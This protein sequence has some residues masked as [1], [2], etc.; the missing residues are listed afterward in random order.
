MPEDEESCPLITDYTE[1]LGFPNKA[2]ELLYRV[3]E[4]DPDEGP[5]PITFPPTIRTITKMGKELRIRN[6][7]T[8]SIAHMIKMHRYIDGHAVG[9]GKS[10]M[11]IT[12]SAYLINKKPGTKVIVLGTKSTTYQWKSEYENFSTLRA[13]VLQDKYEGAKGSEAR[14]KQIE[15]FLTSDNQDV[16]IAKY[17]SLVG[18]RRTLEGE[19]DQDGNP[20]TEG[21]KEEISPEIAALVGIVKKHGSKIVLVLDECQKFKSTTSQIRKMILKIQPYIAVIWAMT[22]TI[23]QNSL[24]EF[25]S[26]SVAIGLR[27]FGPM[28]AFRE[29]FCIYKMVHVGRG[30]H[31]P[32][33]I[34]YKNVKE[35][36]IGMRP[37]YYGRSQAQVKEPLPKLSTTYHPIELDKH[38]AKL[39]DDIRSKKFVLPPS[40]KK[41]TNGEI[42]E[43]ERDPD[44]MMTMLAVT[45][46][47]AN[48]PNLMTPE[49]EKAFYTKSLSPKE[50]M[51]LDLLDGDLAGEKVICFAQPLSAKVL[52]PYGWTTMGELKIGDAVV[53]PDG[54]V[55]FVEGVY[56]QGLKEEF[57]LTTKSGASAYCS[58]DHLWLVQ[59]YSDLRKKTG[60]WRVTT[61]DEIRRRGIARLNKN[62]S[63]HY[64]YF[65][66]K[67]TVVGLCTTPKVIPPYTLGVLLGDGDI[68]RSV[69]FA[70][71]DQEVVD[72]V[73][74]ETPNT[75][76]IAKHGASISYGISANRPSLKDH[77]GFNL[78]GNNPY[79][80]ELRNLG[81]SGSDS[82]SKF[83]P[84][85][86]LSETPQNRLALLQG[87]MDTDGTHNISNN[88]CHYVTT[89]LK[90]AEGVVAL[91]RSL[92]GLS[93]LDGPYVNNYSHKEE[94]KTGKPH[95][96]VQV[97]LDVCPFSLTRKAELWSKV[98][99]YNTI[100]SVEL[101]GN[102]VGMQCIRVSTKRNL[103][104]TDDYIVT[105]N[106]KFR[107]WIDRLEGICKRGYFTDRKFLR[108]TGAEN[109]KKREENKQLFQN[110]PDYN[111]L[112]I[113]SAAAEGVNLQQAA[114]MV[115]LDVPWSWGVTLQLVGRMVRMASPHSA[116]TLHI[117]PAK[118]TVDE[119][120]IDTLKGKGSLFETI[121]G[122]SYSAG[123]LNDSNDLD[124][125]S[126]MDKLNDDAEFVKLLKA[127]VKVMKMGSFI[128]G[129]QVKEA[130]DDPEY[131]MAFEKEIEK[132]GKK[133]VSVK[134]ADFEKWSF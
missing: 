53:D 66:P 58:G 12:S 90:L 13:E 57:K 35:F 36:K 29:K 130:A 21:Q 111:L 54:G 116:C 115:L 82:F 91:V 94:L 8:Q 70:S 92:G 102:T 72:R 69:T 10:L 46:M 24:E 108:I 131:R 49:D 126:G 61:T 98:K 118:G 16:L 2:M 50:E 109:E 114:H 99:V 63:K 119:Y 26:I 134:E 88:S 18:R 15:D 19:F 84:D 117:I 4:H 120:A 97:R 110:D 45:Q 133:R 128:D 68:S 83:I 41:R 81:L 17:T 30:I 80:N 37:F 25:Y 11:A 113:N 27:P 28:K 124:L 33:L 76:K 6:Y 62:G 78:G 20:Q 105:H 40:V 38:Q 79:L 47:I 85:C 122:E 112:V 86:Y 77:R 39:L 7:Q 67:P 74:K 51:L 104:I 55:G 123:L 59:T 43:K 107:T 60:K 132:K 101:T 3:R 32:T 14:L 42:Y 93:K 75:L 100:K 89:S 52:T 44:N 22:A 23:I 95:F 106:T 48:H 9:L 5:I 71:I 129:S 127:H 34:G 103:Y 96:V 56:P 87:L 65:L 121:L 1:K 125:A 31:K 64:R 73:E